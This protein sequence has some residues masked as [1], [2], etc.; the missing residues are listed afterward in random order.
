LLF[1]IEH[2]ELD[3][4]EAV[5]GLQMLDVA[6]PAEMEIV[7]APDLGALTGQ[8]VAQVASDEARPPVTSARISACRS[9]RAYGRRQSAQKIE[10][11]VADR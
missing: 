3:E 2:V 4:M 6:A 5:R 7:D 8:A 10:N 11:G 9:R 1:G